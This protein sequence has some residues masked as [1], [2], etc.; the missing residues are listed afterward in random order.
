MH[1][2][3][4]VLRESEYKLIIFPITGPIVSASM[5]LVFSQ[6]C[7]AKAQREAENNQN[8]SASGLMN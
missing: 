3:L 8:N 5:F 1:E 6:T 7:K 4:N 2:G